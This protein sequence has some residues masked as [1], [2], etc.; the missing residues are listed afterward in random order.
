M[1]SD[2]TARV[3]GRLDHPIIDADGHAIEFMP[4]VFDIVGELAGRDAA[5]RFERSFRSGA[6]ASTESGNVRRPRTG[7]WGLPAR[8][9]LDR[10][11]CTLPELLYRRL[12]EIGI[13]FA[14]LYPTFGLGVTRNTSAEWRQIMARAFNTYYATAFEGYR[15]RLE[16]VATIPTNTPEE[17]IT[18]LDYAVGV[19][20]LKAVIMGTTVMRTTGRDGQPTEPWNDTLGHDSLYDFDPLWA[21]CVKHRVAPSFHGTSQGFGF[22]VSTSNYVYNHI[23]NFAAAQ[24]A[25]CRSIV[26]GG[27]A[28]RFPQLRCSFLE[29]GVTWAAQLFADLLG[30]FD[31]RNAGAMAHYDPANVDLE[32]YRELFETYAD[33]N[34]RRFGDQL[35]EDL[36]DN[37]ISSRHEDR[38]RVDDF[39]ESGITGPDDIVEMFSRRF[40]F[41]CEADD[42]MNTLAFKTNMIPYGVRL[43]A[44]FASDIG[45]WDV[46][47]ARDVLPEAWEMVEHGQCS[48]EDFRDFTFSNVARM[49]TGA[50]PRFF[51]QTV[52]EKA[53]GGIDF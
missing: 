50:N 1:P 48:D 4:L 35:E 37:S 20:G 31:K 27:V 6:V 29:G 18:E 44:M 21:R 34:F 30:H 52:I 7:Y 42:A 8:N 45:H 17:A 32:L 2:R 23:G 47:D 33:Q 15:D 9:T 26:L 36:F 51:D 10:A 19:L 40:Y 41:G 39:A 14:L 22:R 38:S 12:D 16:P 13:D 5:Q 3:R 53:V 46:P 25:A 43:N 24:E 49:L 28:T 11:T